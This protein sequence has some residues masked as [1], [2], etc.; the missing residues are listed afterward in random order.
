MYNKNDHKC[1][2][3]LIFLSNTIILLYGGVTK[4][5]CRTRTSK[6][7][8]AWTPMTR[9]VAAPMSQRRVISH[10][11][12]HQLIHRDICEI[13]CDINYCKHSKGCQRNIAHWTNGLSGDR[14]KTSVI[15]DVRLSVVCNARAPYSGGC[16]FRQFLYGIWYLS[17]PLTC[18]EKFM[19][20]IPGEPLR[21]GS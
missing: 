16:N 21:R 18:T 20:I 14:P 12:H 13:Q 3:S 9:T 6:C 5:R 1:F 7:W 17:H 10:R 15:S 4:L 2:K 19:E 8:G 11:R